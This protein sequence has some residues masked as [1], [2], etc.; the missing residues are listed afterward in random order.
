ML[1]TAPR[2]CATVIA[3]PNGVQEEMAKA[4]VKSRK[5]TS[6][7]TPMKNIDL[8]SANRIIAKGFA[9]ARRRKHPP[10]TLCVVDKGGY[11]VSSQREDE[12]STFQFEI[13]F[14]KAWTCTALGHSTTYIEKNM[15]E[16][17]PHFVDALG[18]ASAG[19]F[20]PTRGGVLIRDPRSNK[21]IGALGVTGD[22]GE[23]DEA[24]AVEAIGKCGFKADLG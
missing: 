22:T 12:S 15:A 1:M 9:L 14:G 5:T 2:R 19:R 24:L 21:I 23:N 20:I 8:A 16:N 10:L 4:I 3:R 11:I 17:R 18:A 7:A 6:A 13:A